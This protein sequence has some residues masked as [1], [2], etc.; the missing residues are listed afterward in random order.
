MNKSTF[1][2]ITGILGI[3][4]AVA[5]AQIDTSQLNIANPSKY[6]LIWKYLINLNIIELQFT[7]FLTIVF[8]NSLQLHW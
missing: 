5:Y 8:S 1:F 6:L 4:L 2:C 3:V 7:A